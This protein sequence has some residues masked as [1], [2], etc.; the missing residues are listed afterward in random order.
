M[1]YNPLLVTKMIDYFYTRD[2]KLHDLDISTSSFKELIENYIDDFPF[3]V[4]LES[5]YLATLLGPLAF[6]MMMY[7][8]ADCMGISG[9]KLLAKDH[10]T[11]SLVDNMTP[12]GFSL[13]I[14]VIYSLTTASTYQLRDIAAQATIDS[15]VD[16]RWNHDGKQ[17]ALGNDLMDDVPEFARDVLVAIMDRDVEHELRSAW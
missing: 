1:K 12:E 11:R 5:C 15:R 7:S 6:H 3:E 10:S 4:G 17:M 14:N 8:L 2:Y 9:L 13:S 16:L